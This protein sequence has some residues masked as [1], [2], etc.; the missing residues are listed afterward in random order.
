MLTNKLSVFMDLRSSTWIICSVETYCNIP[1]LL[2]AIATLA[3]S[4]CNNLQLPS[5]FQDHALYWQAIRVTNKAMHTL[6]QFT[7]QRFRRNDLLNNI[8]NISVQY[9]YTDVFREF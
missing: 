8:L 2:H 4:V 3:G 6:V 7:N 1:Y 5:V 9:S